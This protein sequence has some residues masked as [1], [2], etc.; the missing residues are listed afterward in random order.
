MLQ[1]QK[2]QQKKQ[3]I[4]KFKVTIINKQ[5][6]HLQ[7]KQEEENLKVYNVLIFEH[8]GIFFRCFHLIV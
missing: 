4:Y 3:K 2:T 5:E 6:Q 7:V 1:M 8:I